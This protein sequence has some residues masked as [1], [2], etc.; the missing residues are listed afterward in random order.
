[1]TRLSYDAVVLAGGASRRMAEGID[2]TALVLAGRPM[3]DHVLAAVGQAGTVVVVGPKR[4]TAIP[5]T[6]RHE[7]PPGGGPAAALGAALD[8][9]LSDVVVVVAGD[10]PLVSRVVV[11][12][13]ST[14]LA[15][16]D[17]AD[18]VVALDPQQR[19]QWLLS[20]WYTD[21]LRDAAG[22]TAGASL[23]ETLGALRWAGVAVAEAATVDVD[24]PADVA[25]VEPLLARP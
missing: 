3:L 13:L 2:K 10:Q 11:D 12:A 24:T 23:R 19:P 6:W 1:M 16:L 15:D 5:V 25:R 9:V 22:F 18:G 14:A 20:A 17:A 8:A 4:P 7:E 21:A